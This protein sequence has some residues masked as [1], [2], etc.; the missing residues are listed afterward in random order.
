MMGRAS[1]PLKDSSG[2]CTILCQS[3][4][5]EF[6]KKF[7]YEVLNFLSCSLGRVCI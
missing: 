6:Y 4:K 1:R 2:K 3:S 5:K 7:L